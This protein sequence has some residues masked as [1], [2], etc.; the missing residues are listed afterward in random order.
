MAGFAE[1]EFSCAKVNT[2]TRCAF[3]PNVIRQDTEIRERYDS[4]LGKQYAVRLEVAMDH[5]LRMGAVQG[6]CHEQKNA[7]RFTELRILA[8][9]QSFAKRLAFEIFHRDETPASLLLAL[10]AVLALCFSR[11]DSKAC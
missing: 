3:M 7:K 4:L 10:L 1:R 2:R 9:G 5:A 11:C 8:C 6:Q